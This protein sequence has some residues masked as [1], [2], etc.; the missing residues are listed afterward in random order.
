[1]P[2]WG[3]YEADGEGSSPGLLRVRRPHWPTGKAVEIPASGVE[4]DAGAQTPVRFHHRNR[5]LP[6]ASR[7][8]AS[9]RG[10]ATAA[11]LGLTAL[12]AQSEANPQCNR[13]PRSQQAPPDWA[14]FDT[15]VLSTI[16]RCYY[17]G[18][19]ET[20]PQLHNDNLPA[21]FESGYISHEGIVLSSNRVAVVVS[22]YN[23]D[24]S[25]I[26]AY[27]VREVHLVTAVV[28]DW[29]HVLSST[30]GPIPTNGAQRR[31]GYLWRDDTSDSYTV[32][33]PQGLLL[34]TRA[35]APTPS[36]C[37]WANIRGTLPSE[38]S[39]SVAGGYALQGAWGPYSAG[40][41]DPADCAV[42]RYVRGETAWAYADT[43]VIPEMLPDCSIIHACGWYDP[44]LEGGADTLENTRWPY[45]A[46]SKEFVLW[47]SGQ[48]GYNPVTLVQGAL[49]LVRA[50]TGTSN[51]YVYGM[52][53]PPTIANAGLLIGRDDTEAKALEQLTYESEAHPENWSGLGAGAMADNL[54]PL[55]WSTGPI[56]SGPSWS[57]QYAAFE[58]TLTEGDYYRVG[59]TPEGAP[60]YAGR[61]YQMVAR[62]TG[63]VPEI[64]APA[65]ALR[66]QRVEVGP[67]NNGLF[68]RGV[69]EGNNC[70]LFLRLNSWLAS[71]FAPINKDPLAFGVLGYELD[72]AF[73]T[74]RGPG[75]LGIAGVTCEVDEST[76]TNNCMQIFWVTKEFQTGY[77][78][79]SDV[80][81]L[82]LFR[83]TT[84]G[85][86]DGALFTRVFNVPDG[87]ATVTYYQKPHIWECGVAGDYLWVLANDYWAWDDARLALILINKTTLVELDRIDLSPGT[88]WAWAAESGR[89]QLI[90]GVDA[91]GPYAD[92]FATWAKTGQ[93]DTTFFQRVRYDTPNLTKSTL[94][95]YE[96]GGGYPQHPDRLT[97]LCNIALSPGRQFWL[98]SGRYLTMRED[99]A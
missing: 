78:W 89:P 50:D 83:L 73:Q 56:F 46:G 48:V 84:D 32:A 5:Q 88:G 98:E 90:R 71:T 22:L 67:S 23:Q 31:P 96:V 59:T 45:L 33:C 57:Y 77:N 41:D 24:F 34:C 68:P 14:G 65:H 91:D 17:Q 16:P 75:E 64:A 69:V 21:G 2:D 37:N 92:V 93:P 76:G 51:S 80:D 47:V 55:G 97:E 4:T 10:I 72:I 63:W 15:T 62:Y 9:A 85:L 79:D 81:R 36:C 8:T 12:W 52:G 1:M 39:V 38:C 28:T 87:T 54:H 25:A 70:Y 82:W 42:D 44:Y 19:G 27:L 58:S 86:Q 49:V 6:Y 60:I 66:P 3:P 53:T 18:A 7:R 40:V 30:I 43:V 26:V 35:N 74:R 94:N 13:G 29:L 20:E 95:S 11:S 61:Y 99:A